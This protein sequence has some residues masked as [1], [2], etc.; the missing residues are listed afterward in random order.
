[1]TRP[2][3]ELAAAVAVMLA[4]AFLIGWWAVGVVLVLLGALVA[5]DA[6][7]RDDDGH[8]RRG[9]VN[10]NPVIERWRRAP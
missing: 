8:H 5:A 2:I 1:M 6:V 9:D 10:P 7:L 4:G 3:V